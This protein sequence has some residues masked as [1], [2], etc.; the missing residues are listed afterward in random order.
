MLEWLETRAL[1]NLRNWFFCSVFIPRSP[2][3]DYTL[4]YVV[5]DSISWQWNRDWRKMLAGIELW[6]QVCGFSSEFE[7]RR[8]SIH[9]LQSSWLRSGFF[10]LTNSFLQDRKL[11]PLSFLQVNQLTMN[12]MKSYGVGHSGDGMFDSV[13]YIK[14]SHGIIDSTSTESTILSLLHRPPRKHFCFPLS[15]EFGC[16]YCRFQYAQIH[17]PRGIHSVTS[18]EDTW[19]AHSSLSSRP[20]LFPTTRGIE[21]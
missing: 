8:W 4:L 1:E 13:Y 15:T 11:I 2:L 7:R 9:L 19:L 12:Y 21:T 10:S 20:I 17:L 6:T 14:L 5:P 18:D 3:I 16:V